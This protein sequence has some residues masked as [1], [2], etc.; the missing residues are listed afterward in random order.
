[1][2]VAETSEEKGK[3]SVVAEAPKEYVEQQDPPNAVVSHGSTCK[4]LGCGVKHTRADG[5]RKRQEEIC[6]YH[7]GAPVFHEGSKGYSC[8]SKRVMDFN[9]FLSI[10]PCTTSKA[11]HLFIG[12]IDEETEEQRRTD[13][14]ER[15]ECRMDHYETPKDVHVTIYAKGVDK[16]DCK[17]TF[18]EDQV[19][20]LAAL[21]I[22]V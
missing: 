16:E 9:D 13:G 3:S 8:C 1:M 10:K 15:V 11:G 18:K 6:T 20:W 14:F 7:K 4:R 19:K 2:K 5:E 21:R 17:V 12:S 22:A